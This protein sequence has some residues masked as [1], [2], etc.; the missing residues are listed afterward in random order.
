MLW[1]FDPKACGTLLP[2][3]GIEPMPPALEGEVL[4][5]RLPGKSLDF[6]FSY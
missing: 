4:T 3:Q 5:T 1:F 6:K 2:D